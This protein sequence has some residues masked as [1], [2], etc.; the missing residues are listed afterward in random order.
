MKTTYKISALIASLVLM[1]VVNLNASNLLPKFADESYIDDIPFD[2]ELIFE[3][4]TM[5]EIDFEDEAYINDIPAEMLCVSPD[6]KYEKAILV[7]FEQD[8]E[9]YVDDMPFNTEKIANQ[10]L[11]EAA[12]NADFEIEDEA[13]INDIPFNTSIVASNILTGMQDSTFSCK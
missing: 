1:L 6:C 3:Q 11:F 5:P 8:E 10:Y 4:L 13:Y 7:T 9:V 12:L 2:T